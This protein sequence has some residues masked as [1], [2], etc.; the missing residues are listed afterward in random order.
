MAA[1]GLL[2]L[3]AAAAG[4]WDTAGGPLSRTTLNLANAFGHVVTVI[5]GAAFAAGGVGLLAGRVWGRNVALLAACSWGVCTLL[6]F[7]ALGSF[8]RLENVVLN[9]VAPLAVVT[10][11]NAGRR[12][13]AAPARGR[14]ER[15]LYIVAASAATLTV[16]AYAVAYHVLVSKNP[17][18][19]VLPE[20]AA[21]DGVDM[22]TFPGKA[23]ARQSG[24]VGFLVP[25]EFH[26]V[27][28]KCGAESGH[29]MLMADGARLLHLEVSGDTQ[30][31]HLAVELPLL[32]GLRGFGYARLYARERIGLLIMLAKTYYPPAEIE[33]ISLPEWYGYRMRFAPAANDVH[34]YALWQRA[35]GRAFE[36]SFYLP[37]GTED[38]RLMDAIAASVHLAA[39]DGDADAVYRDGLALFAAG[40]HGEAEYVLARAVDADCGNALF[41]LA[42]AEAIY[43]SGKFAEAAREAALALERDPSLSGARELTDRIIREIRERRNTSRTPP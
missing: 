42:L 36:L 19:S 35:T 15:V 6:A 8:F 4:W 25:P 16:A 12:P 33:E 26:Y 18:L 31:D 1:G 43:R 14:F 34:V 13:G 41:H 29:S 40:R 28:S 30:Y 17:R 24:G 11:L 21:I 2:M 23:M 9:A 20:K 3:S 38:R 39:A 5:G 32:G 7:L 22:R 27:S 37:A 10:L